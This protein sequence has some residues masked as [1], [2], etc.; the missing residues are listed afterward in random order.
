MKPFWDYGWGSV[1]ITEGSLGVSYV[2]PNLSN[3]IKFKSVMSGFCSFVIL[4]LC[5]VC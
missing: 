1:I 5:F 4:K 3:L 2:D